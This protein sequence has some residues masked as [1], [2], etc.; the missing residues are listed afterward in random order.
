MT[1][2]PKAIHTTGFRHS[3][4]T[5]EHEGTSRARS[6]VVGIIIV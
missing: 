5:D 4:L 6:V 3:E 1:S 2:A